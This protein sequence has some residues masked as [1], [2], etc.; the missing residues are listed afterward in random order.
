MNTQSAEAQTVNRH[1]GQA[2]TELLLVVPLVFVLIFGMQ[3]VMF[4]LKKSL[5]ELNNKLDA[6]LSVERVPHW[7]RSHWQ[8]SEFQP[9]PTAFGSARLS[10][11][12]PKLEKCSSTFASSS[13]VVFFDTEFHAE[14]LMR[15]LEQVHIMSLSV[16]RAACLAEATPKAGPINGPLLIAGFS[17]LPS[18][19]LRKEGFSV[20]C[21]IVARSTDALRL[22]AVMR[23]KSSAYIVS[24]KSTKGAKS[25]HVICVP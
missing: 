25:R 12:S 20:L 19:N 14:S 8:T 18:E 1:S 7:Q 9:D 13:S 22:T 4:L 17:N 3:S 16:I 5:A 10:Y 21:P 15:Q 24:P 6:R 2:L 11:L 23:A